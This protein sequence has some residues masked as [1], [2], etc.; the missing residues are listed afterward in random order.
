MVP[1]EEG[2][3]MTGSWL[4]NALHKA[5][6]PKASV[7]GVLK[8]HLGGQSPGR[9]MKI[10]HASDITRIDFCPRR[11]A[12]FD[13]LEK[14]PP[15]DSLS[16]AL[17]VT[18]RM[19]KAT[20]QLLVEEWAGD[21]IVGNWRCRH[22]GEQRTMVPHP[23]GYCVVPIGKRKHWWQYRQLV[24]SA[25]EYGVEGGIDALFNIG[26]PQLMITEIKTINPAEFETMLVPQPEH[27]LR[28]NLYMKIIAESHHPFRE[29]IN[30]SEA[31]VLYISR[32]YGKLN[33]EWNEILPFRE[34]AVTRNDADLAEFLKRAAAL[35]AF[36]TIGLLPQGICTTALDKYAKACSVGQPCFSGTY[37]AGHSVT[38]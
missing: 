37:P 30:T 17:D 2:G 33:A 26:A 12:L 4:R 13:M 11:W 38:L 34:F 3:R 9:S 32:G 15:M 10:L 31:R 24:V 1:P 20:E 27:R 29:K 18:F 22:C 21:A 7:I 28:T 8:Q 6:R 14:D 23:D 19:G 36:R 5:T 35:K 25:P 16:T